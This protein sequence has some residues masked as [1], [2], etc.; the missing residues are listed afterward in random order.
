MWFGDPPA[1][2]CPPPDPKTGPGEE[3]ATSEGSDLE[4]PPELRP[5]MAS[6]LRGSLETS[7][8]E[9][10]VMPLEPVV[11]EFSQWVPWK[12]EKCETPDWWSKLLVVPGM[13]DYRKLAREVWA[14]FQLLQWMQELGM[15]EANLQVPPTTPCL[16]RCRF[17]LLAKLI[18]ACRDI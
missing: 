7:G 16:G 9:G 15:K 2:N 4:E 17:M 14:S 1:P 3:G 12:A 6:F 8:D 18:Y 10:N 5:E 13:E 11:L